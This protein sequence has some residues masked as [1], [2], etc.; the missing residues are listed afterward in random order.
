MREFLTRFCVGSQLQERVVRNDEQLL[1]YVCD[2]VLDLNTGRAVYILVGDTTTAHSVRPIP[3]TLFLSGENPSEL[4]LEAPT[5]TFSD[6][7]LIDRNDAGLPESD[8]WPER[9]HA[10]F[11]VRPLIPVR[12]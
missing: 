4:L 12:L 6:A 1:G 5:Q 8:D 2:V 10:H 7:P 3:F 11:Q 9:I